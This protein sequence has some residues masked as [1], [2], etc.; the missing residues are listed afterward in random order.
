MTC[1]YQEIL[2]FHLCV[3]FV[4][5]FTVISN[6]EYILPFALSLYNVLDENDCIYVAF[7][8]D[9]KFDWN[10]IVNTIMTR[11]HLGYMN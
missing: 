9:I 4:E 7:Y 1:F 10:G 8:A 5:R 11:F 6:T 2:W 3:S